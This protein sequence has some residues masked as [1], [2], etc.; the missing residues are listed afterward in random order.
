MDG[1]FSASVGD[2]H[3]RSSIQLTNEINM[4]GME[5]AV[6]FPPLALMPTLEL[7]EASARSCDT[8]IP[9]RDRKHQFNGMRQVS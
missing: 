9:F 1:P 4:R 8:E 6:S 5:I 7:D 2:Q 3:L